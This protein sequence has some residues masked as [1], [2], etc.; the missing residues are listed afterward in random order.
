MLK[1]LRLIAQD[2]MLSLVALSI[3]CFGAMA[4]SI[5]PHQSMVAIRVF[6]FSDAGYAVIMAMGSALSV[7]AAVGVGILADQRADR[8]MTAAYCAGLG[9]LGGALVF[10]A[11]APWAFGIV[12]VLIFPFSAALFG[13]LFA[14]ARLASANRP[15]AERDSIMAAIRALFAMPFIIIL[16]LWSLAFSHGADLIMVYLFIAMASAII[17]ALLLTRWPSTLPNWDDS[18]SGIGFATAMREIMAAP[19]ILRLVIIASVQAGVTL[20]MMLLGLILTASAGRTTSDVSLFAGLV[21]GLEVPFMLAVPLLLSRI[22][23]SSLIAGAA[24]V[25][26]GFLCAFPLVAGQSAVWALVPP[27]AMG[28]AVI[29]SVPI[30]YLQD[31]MPERPGAGGALIAVLG[32][33]SQV[34]AAAVFAVGTALSGYGLAAVLGAALAATAGILLVLLDRKHQAY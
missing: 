3:I 6:G 34:I 1:P 29:L 23:K 17:V 32:V 10:L 19:V 31:L 28:A 14:L 9:A 2:P 33:T 5:A 25:H 18:K 24:L 13:Q 4:A 12:H 21:A 11:D 16:P 30:A 8:R 27:A 22:S 20:Y 7:V 15:M 26:A